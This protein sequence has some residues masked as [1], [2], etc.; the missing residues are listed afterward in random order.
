MTSL[1]TLR[2]KSFIIDFYLDYI[3]LTSPR[4]QFV[5]NFLYVLHFF[6]IFKV[7]ICYIIND[8][9]VN[10]LLFDLPHFMGGIRL[11][12]TLFIILITL[13]Q[14][15]LF[16][17]LYVTD[18]NNRIYLTEML[19]IFRRPTKIRLLIPY[20]NFVRHSSNIFKLVQIFNK[21]ILLLFVILGKLNF[22]L[23]IYFKSVTNLDKTPIYFSKV[24]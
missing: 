11:Y 6:I 23:T 14:V 22:C 17:L 5:K 10:L 18:N 19:E 2:L 24:N 16:K 21:S 1:C 15:F 20:Q 8:K 3:N 4:T 9:Q 13:H 7:I 12:T